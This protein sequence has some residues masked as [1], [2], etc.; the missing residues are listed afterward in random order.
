MR[1]QSRARV[2]LEFTAETAIRPT[3]P[4]SIWAGLGAAVL[5]ANLY[6]VAKWV[7]G[8]G[9][10]EVPRGP[11]ELPGWMRVSTLSAQ[12]LFPTGALAFLYWF[13]VR[14]WRRDRRVPFDGCF[15]ISLVAISIWDPVS[16]GTQSWLTYNS[17][18]VNRGSPVVELPGWLSPHGPGVAPA[19]GVF[20][21][22]AIY[23]LIPLGAIIGCAFMRALHRRFPTLRGIELVAICFVVAVPF[24]VVF[25]TPLMYLGFWSFPGGV[26]NFFWSGHYYQLPVNELLHAALWWTG[27]SALRYFLD[28]NGCSVAERGATTL[29]GGQLRQV[30]VRTMALVAFSALLLSVTYHLPNLLWAANARAY[31]EDFRHRSYLMNQ[32]GPRIDRACPGPDVPIS[33]PGSGYL[34]WEGKFVTPSAPTR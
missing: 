3:R 27:I 9:F 34:N 30:A 5:G 18:M 1:T 29:P 8:P 14:P 2:P 32:C 25:D 21:V 24:V 15:S 22:P 12:I 19:W 23:A 13:V 4:V 20:F 17:A 11:D 31:P 33:R 16:N 6:F 10:A 7:T 28:D 26:G